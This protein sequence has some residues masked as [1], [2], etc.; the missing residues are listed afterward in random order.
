MAGL[1]IHKPVVPVDGVEPRQLN[2]A[3][4]VTCGYL[5]SKHT[6]TELIY[7]ECQQSAVQSCSVRP[8]EGA[9]YD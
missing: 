3:V 6:V 1:T 8:N 4:F 5:Q 9:H 7:V 2:M